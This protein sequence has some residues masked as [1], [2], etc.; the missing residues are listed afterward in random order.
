MPLAHKGLQRVKRSVLEKYKVQGS[1]STHQ[2]MLVDITFEY[3]NI[4]AIR[5]ASDRKE[6]P[7]TGGA[8]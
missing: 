7:L 3:L 5:E 6:I 8:R 4:I 2:K 1:M